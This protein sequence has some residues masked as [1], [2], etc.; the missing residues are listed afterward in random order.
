MSNIM[1]FGKHEGKTLEWI[2]FHHPH[3]ARFLRR[4]CMEQFDDDE[5]ECFLEL[6]RRASNITGTCPQCRQRPIENLGLS[7]HQNYERLGAINFFCGECDYLG[8]SPTG[9]YPA[10]FFCKEVELSWADQRRIPKEVQRLFIVGNLIQKKMEEYFHND[11]NFSDCTPGF[12]GA[13]RD[14]EVLK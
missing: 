4:K 2:I 1:S 8:G 7:W 10:S 9:Y 12:F 13:K 5:R 11:A 6:Y 14:A 3:Y